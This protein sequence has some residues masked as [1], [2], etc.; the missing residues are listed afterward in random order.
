VL[1]WLACA[2]YAGGIARNNGGNYHLFVLIGLLLGPLG[3]AFT[4][5]IG[6]AIINMF[7]IRIRRTKITDFSF[8]YYSLLGD[9]PYLRCFYL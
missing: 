9:L 5:T 1:V 2:Y 6:T 7:E 8:I 4:L 3:L